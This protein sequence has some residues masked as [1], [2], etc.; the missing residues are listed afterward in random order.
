MKPGEFFSF[1]AA[2]FMAY[3]PLKKLASANVFIQRAVAGANRVFEMLDTEHEFVHDCGRATLPA[4]S[5]SLE[6]Q[7]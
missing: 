3:A 1:L 4:I 2:M 6:F 5:R 7:T